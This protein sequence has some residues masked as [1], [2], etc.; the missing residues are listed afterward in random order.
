MQIKRIGATITA[1]LATLAGTALADA[2]S[3]AAVG[4]CDSNQLCL[5]RS[6]QFRTMALETANRSDC[7]LLEK[8]GL[9]YPWNG[10]SSYVNN[11]PVNATLYTYDNG[12]WNTGGIP[13]GS[14]STDSTSNVYFGFS[15][16]VCTGSATPWSQVLSRN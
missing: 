13:S 11:L 12:W 9:T 10:I 14:L 8:Y 7:W 15:H 5:Y 3:A 4:G 1:L 2:T 16:Y 6:T